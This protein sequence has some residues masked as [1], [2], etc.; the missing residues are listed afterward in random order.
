MSLLGSNLFPVIR[1]AI[2]NQ[3]FGLVLKN[4]LTGVRYFFLQWDRC[5]ASGRKKALYKS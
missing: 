5:K 4:E 2:L 1:C 3:S